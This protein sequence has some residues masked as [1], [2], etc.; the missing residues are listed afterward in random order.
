MPES[1]RPNP[2][3]RPT[4]ALVLGV[5]FAVTLLA[6]TVGTY[7]YFV[8]VP[9]YSDLP[10]TQLVVESVLAAISYLVVGTGPFPADAEVP[11]L[12][13]VGRGAGVL[14]FS[15]A[16]LVGA[17]EL[18]ATKLK[19]Y[20]VAAWQLPGLSSERPIV[21][22]GLGDKGHGI[23]MSALDSGKRVVAIDTAADGAYAD[24]VRE[25]GGIV[26]EGDATG[27]A[28]L[29]RRAK[30]HLAS[31]V[32][33]NCGADR[34]NTRIAHELSEIVRERG[35][36][37]DPVTCHVHLESRR[38]RRFLP[39]DLDSDPGLIVH[40]YGTAM[41]TAREL[42]ARRPILRGDPCDGDRVH[43]V[44]VGW[45]AITRAALHQLHQIMH[46]GD[47]L[48]RQVTVV[49]EDPAAASDEWKRQFTGTD[50]D[51]WN[52]S[53]T[54]AFVRDLFPPVSFVRLP[55]DEDVL[56][57]DRC[58]LYDAF[59]KGDIATVIVD[60]N[61]DFRA[62]SLAARLLPKLAEHERRTG[63][64][65]ELSYFSDPRTGTRK[66]RQ[67]GNAG[68]EIEA[69]PFG[70]FVDGC[71]VTSVRGGRRDR[72]AKQMALLYHVLYDDE[73][74]EPVDRAVAEHVGRDADP[75]YETATA[76]WER[77]DEQTVLSLAESVWRD[78]PEE[79]RDAN[80]H[81]AD[82]VR[83]KRRLLEHWTDDRDEVVDRLAA[84]E[85]RRWCADR[86]LAGWEPVPEARI[87]DWRRDDTPF[88]EQ[89]YH[90]SLRPMEVLA[91]GEY[92]TAEELKDRTQVQFVLDYLTDGTPETSD[93]L[94][95]SITHASNADS[96][97]TV[98][99]YET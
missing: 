28:T 31:E 9:E 7:Q 67:I 33:V 59:R 71:S 36:A 42:L 53:E 63:I 30:V 76:I 83:V 60:G 34:T 81:A 73:Q 48:D 77:V 90:G 78:L 72:T 47:G 58:S 26:F 17:A 40:P 23:A 13:Y 32:Y 94:S 92:K 10:P 22:C 95:G 37:D 12:V 45:T 50:P 79:L 99:V 88:R 24:D 74:T 68:G 85:H 64:D 96:R 91:E 87:D 93:G 49:C 15:S 62:P 4:V 11:L 21:V 25:A 89:K 66:R 14:F 27:R 2:F 41:A 46:Y 18:F 97:S 98:P 51:Q 19:P 16:A 61:D 43:V 5:P 3:D 35:R 80:R 52:D 56:L 38:Q 54:A 86:F 1:T 75:G 82:H 84:I 65:V 20:R 69:R 6:G 55:A 57:S 29:E 8:R 39:S 44:L 70:F